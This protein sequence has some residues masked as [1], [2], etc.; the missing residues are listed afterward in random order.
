MAI[1][2]ELLETE[3]SFHSH[4]VL[5]GIIE[6]KAYVLLLMAGCVASTVVY[7]RLDATNKPLSDIE[8]DLFQYC[9][10]ACEKVSF[11]Y[12]SSVYNNIA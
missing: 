3:R 10:K 11:K 4:S 7:V 5:L 8:R 9:A 12:H 1:A 2:E 6:M